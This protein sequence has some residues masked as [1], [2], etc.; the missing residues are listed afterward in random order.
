MFIIYGCLERT[1]LKNG[2]LLILLQVSHEVTQ[3]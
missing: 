1:D 2:S 3:H